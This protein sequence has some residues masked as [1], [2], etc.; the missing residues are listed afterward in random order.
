MKIE[1]V[2][3]VE[4]IEPKIVAEYNMWGGVDIKIDEFTF[5]QIHYDYRYTSNSHRKA[6]ADQ[7][8]RWLGVDDTAAATR[9]APMPTWN[10]DGD[11]EY[12]SWFASPPPPSIEQGALN[13]N[14]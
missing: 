14:V 8:L 5:V 11:I 1:T 6:M 4:M 12:E 10:R 9:S 2:R 7:V 13:G 3:I